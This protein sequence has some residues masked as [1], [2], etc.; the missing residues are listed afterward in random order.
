MGAMEEGMK[1]AGRKRNRKKE[2]G[3]VGWV[4]WVGVERR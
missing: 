3:W 1:R 4:G 2:G